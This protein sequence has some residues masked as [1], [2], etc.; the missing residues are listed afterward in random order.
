MRHS[1][2]AA[3]SIVQAEAVTVPRSNQK[4]K[5]KQLQIHQALSYAQNTRS[6][7]TVRQQW[8]K[9]EENISTRRS[10]ELLDQSRYSQ[11]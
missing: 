7:K 3:A 5:I 4:E 8:S 10:A 11:D 9:Q 2:T 1:R 6:S